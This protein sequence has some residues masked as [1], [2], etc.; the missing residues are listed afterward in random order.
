MAER[1]GEQR[2]LCV[3]D[4]NLTYPEGDVTG[5]RVCQSLR[6]RGFGG[7]S[8][9]R[10]TPARRRAVSRGAERVSTVKKKA[11]STRQTGGWKF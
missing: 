11:P 8:R 6:A 10:A 9:V 1:L 5:S 7:A 4:E 3:V 2:V